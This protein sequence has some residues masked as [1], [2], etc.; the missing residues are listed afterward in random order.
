MMRRATQWAGLAAVLVLATMVVRADDKA[1]GDLKKLQGTWIN[2][3]SEGPDSTWKFAG[4]TLKTTVNGQDYTCSVKIDEKAKPHATI[5]LSVKDGPGDSSGK[6]AKG[7]YKFDGA[8][9]SLC[10]TRPGNETRP[11]EFKT[12]EEEIYLFDLKKE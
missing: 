9:L 3:G 4:E 7:I 1:S 8:K 11:T 2:A 12:I 10:V 5:D 6:I